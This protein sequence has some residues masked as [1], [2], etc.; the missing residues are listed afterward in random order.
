MRTHWLRDY[1]RKPYLLTPRVRSGSLSYPGLIVGWWHTAVKR[2]IANG[3]GCYPTGTT[4][5][6]SWNDSARR[7]ALGPVARCRDDRNTSG[8]MAPSDYSADPMRLPA[9]PVAVP[10]ARHQV[11]RWLAALSWPT[12]QLD[13]IV[14]AVSEAVTNAVEH[15]Y[16]DQL[17]GV[18]E[19]RGVVE[20]LGTRRHRAI[21]TV[22]DYG[23]W[24]LAPTHDEQEHR[25]ISIMRACADTATIGLPD[26]GRPGTQVVLR[27]KT[28]LLPAFS[29]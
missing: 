15:A 1:R 10:V 8:A 21:I 18:V 9:D 25:G 26:D 6:D 12:A 29:L 27:S 2:S 13:D 4:D 24:R 3:C 22:R 14:L 11:R 5:R 28:V 23:R 20:E 7:H 16:V 19:V 17:P